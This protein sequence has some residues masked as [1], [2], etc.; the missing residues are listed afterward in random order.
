[1]HECLQTPGMSLAWKT[2]I[3]LGI[4]P[5]EEIVSRILA[6]CERTG[7]VQ[8]AERAF[9]HLL[10]MRSNEVVPFYDWH[11]SPLAETY[12]RAGQTRN[13]FLTLAMGR[14]A[15]I[16]PKQS[17]ADAIVAYLAPLNGNKSD[18]DFTQQ[19][20]LQT[21]AERVQAR[22]DRIDQA[23]KDMIDVAQYPPPQ[24]GLDNTVLKG[25]LASMANCNDPLR[26]INLLRNATNLYAAVPAK[27]VTSPPA[28]FSP[29]ITTYNAALISC[30]RIGDTD[31]AE[32]LL[33]DT[34]DPA[35]GWEPGQ[36]FPD[37]N[38]REEGGDRGSLTWDP[39]TYDALIHLALRASDTPRAMHLFR[40]ARQQDILPTYTSLLSLA[41][42]M[43]Q[44]HR[45]GWLPLLRLMKRQGMVQPRSNYLK[46][47][48]WTIQDWIAL[49]PHAP[50]P[51]HS[52]SHR[53]WRQQPL[54][55]NRRL[56]FL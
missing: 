9:A 20:P 7:D 38:K 40:A 26:A 46:M 4:Q 36:P 17:C 28:L 15:G 35:C 41:L 39:H 34:L 8:M 27:E 25:I 56:G 55:D 24:G 42:Y 47:F 1:M 23:I 6:T 43:F 44:H 31:A 2:M 49:R 32:R 19:G 21:K 50:N 52:F 13:A 45:R 51:H 29:D 14:C 5:N 18:S 37:Q 30:V 16:T 10:R 22:E 53:S 33:A 48:G 12:L 3:K 54:D 11:L